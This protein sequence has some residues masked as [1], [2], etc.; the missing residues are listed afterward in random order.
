LNRPPQAAPSVARGA[1]GIAITALG[2]VA[3]ASPLYPEPIAGQ[4]VR[5]FGGIHIRG[6]HFLSGK[7]LSQQSDFRTMPSSV[8]G[9]EAGEVCRPLYRS[10]NPSR[11]CNPS[12]DTPCE[13]IEQAHPFSGSE[14]M[15]ETAAGRAYDLGIRPALQ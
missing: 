5:F 13:I 9:W 14:R 11:V 12:H 4:G 3:D 1:A 2:L 6:S 8:G 7:R 10:A 15:C